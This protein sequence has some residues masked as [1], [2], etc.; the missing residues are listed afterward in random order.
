MYQDVYILH[1]LDALEELLSQ[2]DNVCPSNIPNAS[3]V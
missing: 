1:N 3:R 2:I